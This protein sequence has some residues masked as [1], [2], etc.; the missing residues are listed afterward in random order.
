VSNAIFD[1]GRNNSPA[2]EKDKDAASS[3]SAGREGPAGALLLGLI[4]KSLENKSIRRSRRSGGQVVSM[5]QA[6]ESRRR[7]DLCIRCRV[8]RRLPAS[9]SFL[10]QAKMRP[11]VVVVEDVLIHEAFQMALVEDDYMIEQVAAAGA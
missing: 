4:H 1:L 11:V 2:A 5:M 9:W 10:L 7:N 6:V 3:G 8:R